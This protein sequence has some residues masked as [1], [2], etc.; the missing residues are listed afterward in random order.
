MRCTIELCHRK[1]HRLKCFLIEVSDLIR[2]SGFFKEMD[3]I[4]LRVVADQLL[5]KKFWKTSVL[6][7]ISVKS[8]FKIFLNFTPILKNFFLIFSKLSF[9]FNLHKV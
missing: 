8:V 6:Q 7:Q 2:N 4:Y 3:R 9:F 1:F 5:T